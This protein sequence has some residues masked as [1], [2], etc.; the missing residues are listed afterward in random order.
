MDCVILMLN[1]SRSSGLLPDEWTAVQPELRM[2]GWSNI[3][4]KWE[5]TRL[6]LWHRRHVRT[7]TCV[8]RA[9]NYTW[10][11]GAHPS[12]SFQNRHW[13]ANDESSPQSTQKSVLGLFLEQQLQHR[14]FQD[15]YPGPFPG[16]IMAAWLV[17]RRLW[18][19]S[20]VALMPGG[21]R[22][23]KILWWLRHIQTENYNIRWIHT[24]R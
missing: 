21:L 14:R 17:V 23:K 22:R 1:F 12:L 7:H 2:S 10:A 18:C 15:D 8:T 13:T 19:N 11:A 5:E 4:L 16:W 24:R 6:Y 9:A 3:W 20:I